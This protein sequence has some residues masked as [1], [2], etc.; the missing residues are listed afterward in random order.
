MS[1]S[2]G[3]DADNKMIGRLVF[4]LVAILSTA[5]NVFAGDWHVVQSEGQ[6]LLLFVGPIQE[7]DARNLAIAHLG[8]DA[9][10][11][12]FDSPGGDLVEG[13][14]LALI[15]RLSL[16]TMIT[17]RTSCESACAVAFMGGKIRA[18]EEGAF[19]GIHAP[20]R[21]E[22]ARPDAFLDPQ[23]TVTRDIGNLGYR[24]WLTK[25]AT[26]RGIS[27]VYIDMMFRYDDPAST[28][29]IGAQEGRRLGV[30]TVL[31]Q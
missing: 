12:V 29:H 6:S 13:I 11:I 30:F 9:T 15:E 16:N 4:S 27:R 23:R 24:E 7:G 20:Y 5:N 19:L 21:N 10:M 26:S 2:G 1:A 22:D 25:F 17:K 14:R 28:K 31:L 8:S 3:L 18:G